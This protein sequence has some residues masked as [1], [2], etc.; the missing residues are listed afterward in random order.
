MKPK[1]REPQP[2]SLFEW[3]FAP[4]R[5]AEL[6][7]DALPPSQ[8]TPWALRRGNV[9]RVA[10]CHSTSSLWPIIASVD[11]NLRRSYPPGYLPYDFF[12]IALCQATAVKGGEIMYHL[13]GRAL[14]CG[15]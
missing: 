10:R 7:G 9:A 4:E 8:P 11:R 13:G 14:R 15:V 5:D 1:G 12:A 3:A 2:A 6:V